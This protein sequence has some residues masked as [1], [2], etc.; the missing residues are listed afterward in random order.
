MENEIIDTIVKN[1]DLIDKVLIGYVIWSFKS[2]SIKF[3][4]L[5]NSVN[6]LNAS[7][8]IS[9]LKHDNQEERVKTIEKE[10]KTLRERHHEIVNNNISKIE[11]NEQKIQE[12][13]RKVDGR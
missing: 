7:M 4:S 10:V 12:L 2:F 6:D 5:I 13:Q 9:F 8:K 11:L 1:G 3:D